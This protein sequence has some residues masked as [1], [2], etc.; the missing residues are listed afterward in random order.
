MDRNDVL[1]TSNSSLLQLPPCQRSVPWS[2][3]GCRRCCQATSFVLQDQRRLRGGSEEAILAGRYQ[4]MSR[5]EL[6]GNFFL[7]PYRQSDPSAFHIHSFHRDSS[8]SIEETSSPST[9]C[10]LLETTTRASNSSLLRRLSS[11]SSRR[12][13]SVF[14]PRTEP[15]LKMSLK[16]WLS[17][18]LE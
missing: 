18:T 7:G 5:L 13:L 6:D 1:S 15:S 12:L 2:W 3:F 16:R 9:R 8:P 11:M 4:G 14:R 10:S 17:S